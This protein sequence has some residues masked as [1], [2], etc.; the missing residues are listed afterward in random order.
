MPELNK[1]NRQVCDVYIDVLKQVSRSFILR[2]LIRLLRTSLVIL[3][4]LWLV[5]RKL[6]HGRNPLMVQ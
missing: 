6:L 1:A 2:R 3:F 4:M 5:V